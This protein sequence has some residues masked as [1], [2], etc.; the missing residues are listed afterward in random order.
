MLCFPFKIAITVVC[1]R[2]NAGEG[3]IY[4]CKSLESRDFRGMAFTQTAVGVP[5]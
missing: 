2:A 1:T 3:K 4:E 5:P